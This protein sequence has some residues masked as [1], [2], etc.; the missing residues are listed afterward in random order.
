MSQM[1][2]SDH[3]EEEERGGDDDDDGWSN[4]KRS[5]AAVWGTFN[6]D[7]VSFVG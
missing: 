5:L 4:F 7:F 3:E 6:I 2:S 1:K